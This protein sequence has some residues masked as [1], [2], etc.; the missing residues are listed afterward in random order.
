MGALVSAA[1]LATLSVVVPYSPDSTRDMPGS[2]GP[3]VDQTDEETAATENSGTA[4]TLPDPSPEPSQPARDVTARVTDLSDGRTPAEN[5]ASPAPA[6]RPSDVEGVAAPEAP[7]LTAPDASTET[8]VDSAATQPV[9]MPQT[10]DDAEA[11]A[12]PAA[13]EQ[14]SP[15]VSVATDAPVQPGV[16]PSQAPAAPQVEAELSISTNP[17]Q[18]PLPSV[19]EEESGLVATDDAGAGQD[20]ESDAT[21]DNDGNAQEPVRPTVRRLV[22]ETDPDASGEDVAVLRP[23]IGTPATSLVDRGGTGEGTNAPGA[24]EGEGASTGQAGATAQKP[25]FRYAAPVEVD[26]RLPRMSIVLIDDGSGPLGPDALD[27]FPFP[28][29]FALDPSRPGATARMAKYRALGHEVAAL[30]S[31]PPDAQPTDVEQ[32]LAGAIASVP[33]AVA[34][35]ED[36]E[37]N[38]QAS[39]GAA[40]QAAAFVRESGHGLVFLPNGLNTAEAIAR[41]EGAP[42]VTVFRDFDG[43][44]QNARTKRRFLDGA[45]FRARQDGSAVM[46]GRLTPDT[47]SALLL[48]GLQDR[49]S[50]VAMVPVSR[51]L[52]EAAEPAPAQ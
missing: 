26:A 7:A 16:S 13:E 42:A 31:L 49:A 48:W 46:L 47:V 41:R 45:A 36:P 44:D 9:P 21:P 20:N 5:A 25:L 4:E 43:E 50:S 24:E 27:T 32:S 17:A 34:L 2:D 23:R 52:Q 39:R 35:I 3:H 28:V 22:P 33:E 1:G 15:N 14:P 19:P 37:S 10:A 11:L 30:A 51:I 18:P 8:P 6:R 12:P 29:T 38:L 40:E